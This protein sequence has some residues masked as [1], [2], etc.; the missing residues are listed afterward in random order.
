LRHRR[1]R[2]ARVLVMRGGFSR[3][4]KKRASESP[5]AAVARCFHFQSSRNIKSAGKADFLLRLGQNFDAALSIRARVYVLLQAFEVSVCGCAVLSTF[6]PSLARLT[7]G[8]INSASTFAFS[9]PFIAHTHKFARNFLLLDYN[10]YRQFQLLHYLA[11]FFLLDAS[12]V[13]KF[14]RV[15]FTERQHFALEL[16]ISKSAILG[17]LLS[18]KSISIKDQYVNLKAIFFKKMSWCSCKFGECLNIFVNPR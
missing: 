8:K 9:T 15:C 2:D 16:L 10:S 13:F 6:L 4:R 12:M 17:K 5:L 11:E 3:W 18:I 1:A 7:I 14:S